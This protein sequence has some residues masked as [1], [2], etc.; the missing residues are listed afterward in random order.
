MATY[1]PEPEAFRR[2]VESLRA[3][4]F[5]DW[6]CWVIDDGS[7]SE[8]RQLLDVVLEGDARFS[9]VHHE[10]NIGFYRNFER[11]LRDV[12][13]EAR[14]IALS[15]QDDVWDRDK[16]ERLMEAATAPP[17]PSLVYADVR[18]AGADGEIVSATYWTGRQHNEDDLAALFFANTVTGAACLFDADILRRALPFP[19]QH[20]S[21]FHDHWLALVARCTGGIRYVD[22][23]VQAYVQHG[24]NAI[25]HQPG[26]SLGLGGLLRRGLSRR[27][28]RRPPLRYYDDEVLRLTELAETLL[29]RGVP[30]GADDRKVLQAVASLHATAPALGWLTRQALLE[31]LDPSVTMIR[32]RRVLASVL[33]TQLRRCRSASSSP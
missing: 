1:R 15:D 28:W 32:R 26:V 25:G 14:W 16:L 9:V 19:P 2:Q 31:C 24:N 30:V 27:W 6:H 23:P 10:R 33:W 11:G 3:Q 20:P 12:A 17:C 7:G 8:T 22:A 5:T 21:S 29:R 18:I 13:E 4:S